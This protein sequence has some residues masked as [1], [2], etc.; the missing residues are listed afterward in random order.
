MSAIINGDSPSVTF[1]DGTTQAT[2]A[3]VSG[4]VPYSVLPAGS[5]LQV[6]TANYNTYVTSASA[7][8]VASGLT[9]TITPKFSTSKVL[10]LCTPAFY[11]TSSGNST[12]GSGAIYKNGSSLIANTSVVQGDSVYAGLIVK[13]AID[14][15]DSPATTSA[16]TYAFYYANT[17]GTLVSLNPN[18]QT[19][20]IILMEIAG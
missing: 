12:S 5:V 10:I 16:T 17:G 4:K 14:Y 20:T 9:A 8:Y 11:T 18:G 19:S 15:L 2:S 6:V 7:S 13:I 1:S 3:V